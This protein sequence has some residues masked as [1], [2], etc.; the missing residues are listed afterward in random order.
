MEDGFSYQKKNQSE[1]LKSPS[2]NQVCLKVS[3]TLI[4]QH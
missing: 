3:R 2:T 4:E 1:F